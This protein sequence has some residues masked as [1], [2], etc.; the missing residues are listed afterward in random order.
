MPSTCTGVVLA[1]G[2][3]RRMNGHDKGLILL[4]GR[5]LAAWVLAA[6]AP[7]VATT[8]ISANRH[9]DQYAA[10][11]APVVPDAVPDFAG[12]LAG[13]QSAMVAAK[14]AWLLTVPGDAPL[15][16]LD[17]GLRLATAL[18]AAQAEVA[19]AT[20]GAQ[21]QPLHALVPV[22]LAA[23]LHAY[24]ASGERRVEAW[25]AQR[26]V[27]W[28]DFSEQAAA[29]LNLNTPAEVLALERDGFGDQARLF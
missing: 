23:E 6:L 13:V 26:R 21:R 25:Y 18:V 8:L 16:P 20:V 27:V 17:L 5:P 15:V 22:H 12:P 10:L 7:Q 11:G 24:L 2:R 29:F 4:A 9:L 1:G 3:A 28:V 19:V 14:T